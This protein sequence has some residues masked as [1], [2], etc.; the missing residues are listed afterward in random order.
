[1]RENTKTDKIKLKCYTGTKADIIC[2]EKCPS[3]QN[4]NTNS[5]IIYNL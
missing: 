4:T 5:E 1:M 3:L 2:T